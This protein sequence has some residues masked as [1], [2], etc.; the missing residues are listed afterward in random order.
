MPYENAENDTPG[1]STGSPAAI[2]AGTPAEIPM[3]TWQIVG[4]RM[5]QAGLCRFDRLARA[6]EDDGPDAVFSDVS[7]TSRQAL[8]RALEVAF[9]DPDG[10]LSALAPPSM[11]VL[12]EERAFQE[13]AAQVRSEAAVAES[14]ANSNAGSGSDNDA[15]NDVLRAVDSA[16][17][18]LRSKLDV[19]ASLSEVD[20]PASPALVGAGTPGAAVLAV[21]DRY[22]V[23][24]AVANQATP[25]L[26][27]DP[28]PDPQHLIG[29]RDYLRDLW[30]SGQADY[31]QKLAGRF[32]QDFH[33]VSL[34]RRPANEILI[35]VL[36]R[37][38]VAPTGPGHGLGIDP[39]TIPPRPPGQS[40]RAYLDR[41]IALSGLSGTELGLRYRLDFTRPDSALSSEV[42]E[43]IAAIR[44]FFADDFQGTDPN[45]VFEPLFQGIAPFYLQYAEWV[46]Q[47][48]E[49]VP[50]N[51]YQVTSCVPLGTG[52]DPDRAQRLLNLPQAQSLPPAR[53]LSWQHNVEYYRMLWR[54][55]E[56]CKAF[57]RLEFQ[58]ARDRLSE[59]E[60]DL[61]GLIHGESLNAALQARKQ[62]PVDNW[63]DL[64]AFQEHEV[65]TRFLG[66]PAAI[67]VVNDDDNKVFDFW[68]GESGHPD[69]DV[70]KERAEVIAR[71]VCYAMPALRG[72]I[73]VATGDY[74][75]ALGH[76]HYNIPG[77]GD[78]LTF[79]E[80]RVLVP[81]G[82]AGLETTGVY[83]DI[84]FGGDRPFSDF[85]QGPTG[86]S[87]SPTL[88]TSGSIPYTAKVGSPSADELT[89]PLEITFSRLRRGNAMLEWADQLYRTDEPGTVARARE[90]YKAVLFL[91]GELP[92]TLPSWGT[93]LS[94][95]LRA[96]ENPARTGQVQHARLCLLQIA[97][98]LN[99]FGYGEDV[100]PLLRYRTLAGVAR[101]QAA[102]AKSA[103]SD[104]LRAM[105][106]I[107]DLIQNEL[108][109]LNF[110]QKALLQTGIAA[111][112]VRISANNTLAA[113]GQVQQVKDLIEAKRREIEDHDSF[114]GQVGDFI[115]H[116]KGMVT[117]LPGD[118]KSATAAGVVSTVK[119][120]EMVG[121][122]MFGAG[123]AGSVLTGFA[124]F[125]VVS[126]ISLN[127]MASEAND[128]RAALT[129]LQQQTLPLAQAQLDSKQ[130]EQV[131]AG[132][133]SQIAQA[134]AALANSLLEFHTDR[135]L[136]VDFWVSCATV[137]RRILR[138][139]LELGSRT[140]WLAERALAYEQDRALN[141]VKLD[142]FPA[143][144]VG[145]TGADQLQLDLAQLEA[146]R[147][148]G[149][150]L[151]VPVK[152]TFSLARDFPLRFS[153]LKATGRCAFRTVETPL[154]L[155]YPGTFGHR[156]RAVTVTVSDAALRG[157]PRG[158][159][160][161]LGV[162][163][164]STADPQ[165][166]HPSVR[167]PDA[168]PISEFRLRNDM[169]IYGLPDDSLL[170]FEGS[171]IDTEWELELPPVANPQG[172][173]G[174]ADI[175]ITVDARA[176][177]SAKLVPPAPVPAKSGMILASASLLDPA[178]FEELADTVRTA[179]MRFDA[180]ELQLPSGSGAKITNLLLILRGQ[181]IEPLEATL[182]AETTG[183]EIDLRF[184]ANAARTNGPPLDGG[185]P[186]PLNPLIG[187]TPGQSFVLTVE[188]FRAPDL[189]GI[190]DVLLCVEYTTGH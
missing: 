133:Q 31:D 139:Y 103:E 16:L 34:D 137:S 2:P 52:V 102:L 36:L 45:S 50:E 70:R 13:Y 85:R 144:T 3:D 30:V 106:R 53:R 95:F 62:L 56:A 68:A 98:G 77:N 46:R 172:L 14:N 93:A 69:V 41:L 38:L 156:I 55:Q 117:D 82:L 26:G 174:L 164:I 39:A 132:L 88:F 8:L 44:G 105:G 99:Y 84:F 19:F 138:R 64:T 81:V 116:V 23:A 12:R 181:D 159:L 124:I 142:Y 123:A 5:R 59:A 73:D 184:V 168:L 11:A 186:S 4:T 6:L 155:A 115:D 147:L 1:I 21:Q 32:H 167:P 22:R 27:P 28:D 97:A 96:E 63:K 47:Y 157:Q 141:L 65:A 143:G 87:D 60:F 29:Y 160:R 111:E 10:Q 150:D 94:G 79:I 169:G 110:R 179:T 176:R 17:S 135:T 91:H 51:Q 119:S 173:S 76:Y 136:N 80:A 109:L 183:Q 134:D 40:A 185:T 37:A 75:G 178:G 149:L 9:C 187:K 146:A 86:P 189:T 127:G 72:D 71:V 67:D 129:A 177:F 100:V 48:P 7:P 107:E 126:V 190:R 92:P 43:N 166:T 101:E 15:D 118:T 151:T 182:R 170:A 114:L 66:P 154:R 152:H 125:G 128:R 145:V 89:H 161:N 35:P 113:V 49:F 122:G 112:Q 165:V 20:W 162:S 171:G 121:S 58:L 24:V 188:K 78:D 130:R 131:I 120:E 61:A 42:A 54:F 180:K 25:A 148:A 108:T 18:E 104:L 57:G 163:A 83:T 74:V 140:A 175:L 33:T 158:I 153:E 90:L